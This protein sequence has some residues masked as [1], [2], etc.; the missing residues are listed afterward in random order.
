MVA[1]YFNNG[2]STVINLST[3]DWKM[4]VFIWWNITDTF[5]SRIGEV[6]NKYARVWFYHLCKVKWVQIILYEG[7]G[8]CKFLTA[9]VC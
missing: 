8:Y 6:I 5:M 1:N 7:W 4:I 2:M 3:V 9:D